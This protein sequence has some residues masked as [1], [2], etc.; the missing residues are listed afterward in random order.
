MFRIRPP[1]SIEQMPFRP[2]FP[3][4]ALPRHNAPTRLVQQRQYGRGPQY[5][6][7]NSTTG[8]V[9]GLLHRWAARPT[10]YRDIGL[11][12]AGTGGVY[13]YNLEE[14]PVS[15]RRRFNIITPGMEEAMGRASVD[16]IK[17]TYR[18]RILPEYD[19]RVRMVKKVLHRLLP[20]AEGEGL[21]DLDWEVTVIDSPE[22]NAFVAPGGKVFVFTGILPLCRDENGIAAVLGHE[23]AHVVAHHTAE[24]MSQAP[25]VLLGAIA[26][27]MFDVSFYSGKMLLDLFLSMPASR[28]HEAEADYIG[29]LMMAQGCYRPEA[30]MEFWARME[31]SG[32]DGPPQILSTH[33][34]HHNRE[35]K[36][37][38]WLPQAQKKAE[39]SDCHGTSQYASRFRT[40]LDS[41]EHWN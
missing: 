5:K 1:L 38:E 19:P 16:E 18:G 30:A 13:V 22:E 8:G 6:R 24:R 10:F 20:Y 36:I 2:L 40:A 12:T 21:R 41:L 4:F 23:I 32:R 37:R 7:F 33:P 3:R 9:S 27:T 14:V 11:I 35:E 26:L 39:Q 31:K 17:Q 34:S 28:K 25:L 29:L 15:G